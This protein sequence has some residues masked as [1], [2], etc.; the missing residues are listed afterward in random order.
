MVYRLDKNGNRLMK[1]EETTYVDEKVLEVAHI[2]EWVRKNPD[3]L[4]LKDEQIKIISKQQMYKTGK[5]SD[6]VAID[7]FGQIV[8]IEL[9][10]DIAEPLS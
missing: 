2:E 9:K 5:R 4:C 7:S 1:L 8:I 3:L 10:R 6:L